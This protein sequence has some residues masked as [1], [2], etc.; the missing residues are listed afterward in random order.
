MDGAQIHLNSDTS[1]SSPRIDRNPRPIGDTRIG[2]S[3]AKMRELS[4]GQYSAAPSPPS[5][6]VSSRPWLAIAMVRK[7]NAHKLRASFHT[8]ASAPAQRAAKT[9]ECV[10]PRCPHVSAYSMPNLNAATSASGRTA[11]AAPAMASFGEI[12]PD[13]A[14]TAIASGTTAW[15]KIVGKAACFLNAP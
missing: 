15:V 3:G 2:V 12:R 14:A 7:A 13:P 4:N 6:S 9:N 1:V 5:V 10:A 8:S 11:N